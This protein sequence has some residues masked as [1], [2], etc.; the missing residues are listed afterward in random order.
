MK[1]CKECKIEY[2]STSE[3]FYE[4]KNMKSG[5]RSDCI[6]CTRKSQLSYLDSMTLEDRRAMKKAEQQRN[7]H[8]YRQAT[9][10]IVARKRGVVHEDWTEKQLI[11]T[12][13]SDCYICSKPID[14]DAPKRGIGSDYSFWPDHMT[15]TSRG[16]SNTIENVR[17]CHRKCNQNKY[18]MTYEEY[19]D[20]DRYKS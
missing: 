10:K 16:G 13:G 12:Y 2:P 9:R 6:K 14:F 3:Y 17:P 19:I 15:P 7:P 8:I 5:L 20:S 18:T 11:D 4:Q 1:T